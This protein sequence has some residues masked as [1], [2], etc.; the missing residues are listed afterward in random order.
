VYYRVFICGT[1]V[2]AIDLQLQTADGVVCGADKMA[3]E[4]I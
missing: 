3:A 2:L 4:Q 1:V